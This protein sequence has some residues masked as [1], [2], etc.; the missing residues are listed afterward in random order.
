VPEKAERTARRDA[1]LRGQ[2]LSLCVAYVLP[3][4]ES[5][6]IGEARRGPIRRA[7]DRVNLAGFTQQERFI[8]QWHC[9]L[10]RSPQAGG[11]RIAGIERESSGH[12]W[13]SGG[14]MV[15]MT[16]VKRRPS[17]V[18][19]RTL[20]PAD[21]RSTHATSSERRIPPNV[22]QVLADSFPASDPPSWTNAISRLAST[23][24]SQSSDERFVRRIRTEF[25][26]MPGLCLTIEQAQRLWSVEPRRCEA[27]LNALIDSRF[28]RRT[29]RGLFV[30]RSPPR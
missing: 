9:I 28:L 30:L 21:T 14:S 10:K 29:D 12:A 20:V 16:T 25:L 4:R 19:N 7:A 1:R 11:R 3:I 24:E 13:R 26:E 8:L 5:L 6:L 2:R 18:R 22:D 27:V 17:N 23:R 15:A